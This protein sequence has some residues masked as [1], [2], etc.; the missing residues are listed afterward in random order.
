MQPPTKHSKFSPLQLSKR[1]ASTDLDPMG[2]ALDAE[3][4]DGEALDGEALDGEALHDGAEGAEDAEG[5]EGEAVKGEPAKH[6]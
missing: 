1:D 2:E 5:A 4:L 3:A 6:G